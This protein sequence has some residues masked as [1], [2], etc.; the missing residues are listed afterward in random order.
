MQYIVTYD[1]HPI[2]FVQNHQKVWSVCHP[3]DATV[4]ESVDEATVALVDWRLRGNGRV[5]IVEMKEVKS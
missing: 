4:F 3:D 2:R 5:K 1:S